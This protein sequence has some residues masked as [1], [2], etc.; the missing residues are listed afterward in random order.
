MRPMLVVLACLLGLLLARPARACTAFSAITPGGPL[1]AKG[2]DW[3][4]GDGWIVVNERGRTRA[5]LAPGGALESWV[6]RYASL[7]LTTVGPGFPV[8]GMNEAG[9]AIEALVDLSS[10]TTRSLEPGRLTG[11]EFIQYGLDRFGSVADLAG[12]AQG[13]AISQVAVPLHF[14]ACDARGACV[15]IEPRG[16]R[17]VVTRSATT[18]VLANR[19]YADDLRASRPSRLAAWLGLGAPARG[20]S[21]GRFATVARALGSRPLGDEDAA[22]RLLERV[23]MP[24]R[25]QWQIV[26]N[27]ERRTVV[28]R[29]REAGLGTLR[30][31]FDGLDLECSGAPRVKGLGAVGNSTFVA[32]ETQDV[33]LSATA[34]QGQIGEVGPAAE[35][36]AAR[37]ARA[38]QG[39]VCLLTPR[40]D[41]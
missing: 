36:L 38:T 33:A 12:F 37:V 35:G 34:V 17:T 15:S 16:D 29:Q 32:W 9:L 2:F 26:W 19:P 27:L 28:V 22:L 7:S 14:L 6:S 3:V 1:L 25:T 11:L 4:T 40:A 31:G 24:G 10:A 5:P 8:S 23:V 39:S 41:R 18:P 20:S 13:I 21:A 30:L